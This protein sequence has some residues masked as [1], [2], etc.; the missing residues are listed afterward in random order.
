VSGTHS[1]FASSVRY[2]WTLVGIFL[3][4][5]ISLVWMGDEEW[6]SNVM[7]TLIFVLEMKT[8]GP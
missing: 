5:N 7:W 1:A 4:E 6:V 3:S 2:E 8:M